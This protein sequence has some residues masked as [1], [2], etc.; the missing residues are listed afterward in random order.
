MLDPQKHVCDGCA[1]A[2]GCAYQEQRRQSADIWFVAHSLL[3]ARPPRPLAKPCL[4]WIDETPIDSALVGVDSDEEDDRALP[5]AALRRCD[6]ITGQ[7]GSQPID[8]KSCAASRSLRWKPC[9]P[10]PWSRHR[11]AASD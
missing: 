7:P 2:D 3:Y 11:S 9:R 1:L 8:C 4:I 5:L 6:P 10:A